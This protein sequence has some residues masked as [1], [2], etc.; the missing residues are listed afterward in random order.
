MSRLID[1]VK[2]IQ[3]RPENLNPKMNDEIKSAYNDGWN[4]CN[5]FWVNLIELQ[6]TAYDIDKVLEQLKK[7]YY[8]C[9]LTRYEE[10]GSEYED[11]RFD[12]YNDALEIVKKG[13]RND[14]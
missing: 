6:S 10:D 1:A 13:G 9:D 2:L 5:S 7:K 12:A 3:G 8:S 11:G 14:K 4:T